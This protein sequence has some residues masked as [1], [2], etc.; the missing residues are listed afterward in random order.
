MDFATAPPLESNFSRRIARARARTCLHYH[1]GYLFDLRVDWGGFA[2]MVDFKG[3]VLR[4]AALLAETYCEGL[5]NADRPPPIP[6]QAK[7]VTRSLGCKGFD[8]RLGF[9]DAMRGIIHSRI[10]VGEVADLDFAP[11]ILVRDCRRCRRLV[12]FLAFWFVHRGERLDDD[13]ESV[14]LGH[15]RHCRHSLPLKIRQ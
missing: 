1:Y 7:L 6:P 10:V 14:A 5:L 13:R 15:C 8:H 3:T 9:L 11:L 12:G 2:F 4:I